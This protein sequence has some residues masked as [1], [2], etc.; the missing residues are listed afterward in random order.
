MMLMENAGESYCHNTVDPGSKIMF[1]WNINEK[2]RAVNSK[3][4]INELMCLNFSQ[5][6]VCLDIRLPQG[7]G[8]WTW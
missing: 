8:T 7:M 4:K 2:I 5:S 3:I 1:Q 6:V